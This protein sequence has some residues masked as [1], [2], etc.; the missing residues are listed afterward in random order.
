MV[1]METH[2]TDR[3][4]HLLFLPLPS[5]PEKE[6]FLGTCVCVRGDLS[7]SKLFV[8]AGVRQTGR[9]TVVRLS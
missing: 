6:N 5:L 8:R 7:L 2:R 1:K 3:K 4:G 9:E